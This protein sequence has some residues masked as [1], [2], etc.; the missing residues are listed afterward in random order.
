MKHMALTKIERKPETDVAIATEKPKYPY[1]LE[2]R[3]DNESLTKLGITTLPKVGMK[4]RLE[5]KVF[6]ESVS[7]EERADGKP[8]RHVGLQITDMALGENPGDKSKRHAQ[9]LYGKD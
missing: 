3:L 5:A 8:N 1:G 7:E 2:L 9:T 4:L 6:V